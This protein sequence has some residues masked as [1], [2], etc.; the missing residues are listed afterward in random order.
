MKY[1][2]NKIP[3]IN[4]INDLKVKYMNKVFDEVAIW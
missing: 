2:W 1:E 3:N 4:N